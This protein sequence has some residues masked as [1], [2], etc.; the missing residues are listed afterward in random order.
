MT[1]L[2]RAGWMLCAAAFATL[3]SAL[4]RV[5]GIVVPRLLLA[6]MALAAVVRP[7]AAIAALLAAIPVAGILLGPRWNGGIAWTETLVCAAI[8]GLSIEAAWKPRRVGYR[9]GIPALAFG[10]IVIASMV[11]SIG[12]FAMRLGPT[13][14][15]VLWQ[16]LTQAYF[17]DPRFIPAV[18]AGLRLLEGVL[19]FA[20]A[21]RRGLTA[22][23]L[24][25]VTAAAVLGATAAGAMNLMR[26]VQ[27]AQR[28]SSFW[29]SLFEL[30]SRLRWNIHYADYNAAGSY[31]VLA[32][33][34]ACG[35]A[36]TSRR[37]GRAG[38]TLSALIIA[39]ALWLTSSRV[40]FLAAPIALGGA[41]LLPHIAAARAR[42]LKLAAIA[43]GGA[44]VLVLI[45]VALPQR[46]SQK[47]SLL[48]ADVRL[49][50]AETAGRMIATRPVFGIGLGEFYQR[51]GEFSSQDLIAKF[52]V[53]VHENAHN[54][55]LQ[56]AAELGLT[57]GLAFTWLIVAALAAVARKAAWSRDT[58]VVFL[59]AGLGAFV[60][61]CIGGHPL[62]IAEPAFVF[63]GA[64]G[65]A[66]GFALP[67]DH[68]PALIAWL[69]AVLVVGIA[70]TLPMRMQAMLQDADLEHAGIGVSVWQTAPDG[71]R[72]REAQGHATL[73]VQ[74]GRAFRLKVRPKTTGSMRLEIKLEGRVADIVTL[75]PEA[76]NEL[77]IPARSEHASGRYAPLDLRLIDGD[78]T[79]M[80][81]TKVD[82]FR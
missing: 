53:A 12:V 13:Y 35:L 9:L 72:F 60:L 80:W 21:A 33:L 71:E 62:L 49:G 28:A 42:A 5:D 66:A 69:A 31:F 25:T 55:F 20:L 10:A 68:P 6:A 15:G 16:H 8:V 43:A 44:V 29:S 36:A 78:Q 73:F 64:L 58:F 50:L 79:L 4:L 81:I 47:S 48:A 34:F 54:N 59:L 63:W 56:V 76:W 57:G 3:L 74:A 38:W 2:A 52:P 67:K 39:A 61:T 30:A 82:A 46:G 14:T 17:V 19:L 18:H 51:S 7:A 32:L 1:A 77:F 27:A 37:W 41:L 24:R 40:A 65:A 11:A 22:A 45:A 23:E 75:A 70:L 26:L